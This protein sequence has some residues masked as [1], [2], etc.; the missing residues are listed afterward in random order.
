MS[1]AEA[2]KAGYG[3]IDGGA[4]KTLGSIHALQAVMDKNVSL[5]QDGRVL[6]VDT[7]EKPSF[8]FGNSSRDTCCSTTTLGITADDR[9]GE[10]KVHTL[11]KGEGPILLS[12]SMLRS[13]GAIIDFEHDLVAFR[14][15]NPNKIIQAV[16]SAAGHQLLPLSE[17]LYS[18][19]LD[20]G[21]PAP[22]L[23]DFCQG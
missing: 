5:H 3:V 2:V 19:A 6:R 15:L 7:Q 4:T 20:A 12:I 13:L 23:R 16:R 18:A 22:S 8:G 9:P 21:K 17:D 14:H 1:T 11:D 10:L